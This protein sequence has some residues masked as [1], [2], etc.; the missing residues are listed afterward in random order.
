MTNAPANNVRFSVLSNYCLQWE[1]AAFVKTRRDG[2]FY[3]TKGLLLTNMCVFHISSSLSPKRD[4]HLTWQWGWVKW[5]AGGWAEL[6]HGGLLISFLCSKPHSKA[7]WK[8]KVC[9]YSTITGGRTSESGTTLAGVKQVL[10]APGVRL[11]FHF[12]NTHFTWC[13]S[14]AT[15]CIATTVHTQTL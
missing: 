1:S 13:Y 8:P 11:V 5:R 9:V 6:N 15:A 2:Y 12:T 14:T 4:D 3:C 10:P 7:Q